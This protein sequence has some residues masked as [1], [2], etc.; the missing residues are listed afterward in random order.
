MAPEEVFGYVY[1]R[2]HSPLYRARY[3]A[4]LKTDFPRVPRPRNL[5]EFETYAAWGAQL[6]ALHT[7]DSA[8]APVLNQ[9]RHTLSPGSDLVEAVEY[10]AATRQL[11][12]N[13]A[14]SWNDVAPEV[15]GARIGGY[16]VAQ[17][18]LKDRRGRTLSYDERVRFPQILIALA[19][20]QKIV[21][22]IEKWEADA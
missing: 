3:A 16:V 15:A 7:L 17:K 9:N 6:V 12:I 22:E 2:L 10:R 13:A 19:Q 1:A 14:Q 20:T 18:W 21:A 11:C 8:A 4:F 5:A